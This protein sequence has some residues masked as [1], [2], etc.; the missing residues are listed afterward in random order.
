L[1]TLLVTELDAYFDY[2]T[3]TLP[4]HALKAGNIEQWRLLAQHYFVAYS[5]KEKKSTH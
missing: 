5:C 3:T 4:F 1:K 2:L